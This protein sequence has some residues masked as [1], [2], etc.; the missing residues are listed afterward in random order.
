MGVRGELF[1]V[2]TS[3]SDLRIHMGTKDGWQNFVV[4][5][6]HT[7]RGPDWKIS[8]HDWHPG[9]QWKKDGAVTVVAD[10][11]ERQQ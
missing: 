9:R 7:K 2:N 4:H 1:I 5:A 11:S 6:G 3:G 8:S 10:N